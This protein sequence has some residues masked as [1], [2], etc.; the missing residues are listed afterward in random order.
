MDEK[1]QAEFNDQIALEY[2]SSYAYL[3]MASWA[4]EHDL[5]GTR[6]WMTAQSAEELTHAHKFID[7]VHD[8][9]GAVRLQTLEAPQGDFDNVVDL[10]RAAYRHEQT[11]SAAIGRLYGL[12]Q[13]TGE[14]QSLPL[15]SWFLNEQVEEEATV[16]TILSE[17][18]MV[19][20]DNSALL[21]L[22]RELGQRE[23]DAGGDTE[24]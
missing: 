4:D 12:A 10:F 3:Q 11:V 13:E 9:D 14:Y 18:E 24:A 5:S 17:L 8:R 6:A 7:H 15:L 19:A 20:D 22:D 1:L 2:A 21:M 23:S 16:R